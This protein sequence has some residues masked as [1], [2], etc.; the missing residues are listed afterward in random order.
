[1]SECDL[2][3]CEKVYP[4]ELL[5]LFG[6]IMFGSIIEDSISSLIAEPQRKSTSEDDGLDDRY[7]KL[8]SDTYGATET[9]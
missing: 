9:T 4:M 5:I 7:I 6:I 1:M 3:I 8:A 2:L